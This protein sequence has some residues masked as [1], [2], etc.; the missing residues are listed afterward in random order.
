MTKEITTREQARLRLASGN[1]VI[2]NN[3][4]V[5]FL[6]ELLRDHVAFGIVEELV[7]STTTEKTAYTNGWLAQYAVDLAKRLTSN[8]K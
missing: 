2:D 1:I 4:L 3:R 6:Y 5:Q 8:A 7:L